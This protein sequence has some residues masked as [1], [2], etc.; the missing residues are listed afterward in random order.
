M[1]KARSTERIVITGKKGWKR[2][3]GKIDNN[4]EKIETGNLHVIKVSVTK[5]DRVGTAEQFVKPR[6]RTYTRV[7]K[8]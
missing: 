8:S 4:D 2:K 6:I 3:I 5:A 7:S 1:W